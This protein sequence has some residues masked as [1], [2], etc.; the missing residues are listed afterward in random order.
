MRDVYLLDEIDGGVIR[1]VDPKRENVEAEAGM[2]ETFCRVRNKV[3]VIAVRD[4]SKEALKN[5]DFVM[6]TFSPGSVDAFY[7]DLE[8]PTK[9]G[10]RIP[11][12]MI[13]KLL[14]ANRTWLSQFNIG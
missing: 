2:L 8:I 12:S 10:I 1:L 3:Y 7:H 14:P 9:Y 5:A 11:V 4:D 13:D 6:T